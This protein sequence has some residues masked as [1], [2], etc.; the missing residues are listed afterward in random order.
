MRVCV[1]VIINSWWY[2]ADLFSL[3]DEQGQI[4]G[5]LVMPLS[6]GLGGMVLL[7]AGAIGVSIILLLKNRRNILAQRV[8]TRQ[9]TKPPGGMAINLV[10]IISPFVYRSSAI[11]I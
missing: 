10:K 11:E 8:D 3:I 6:A 7:F 5:N 9:Y 1:C 2:I 4:Q